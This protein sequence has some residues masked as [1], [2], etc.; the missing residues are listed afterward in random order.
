VNAQFRFSLFPGYLNKSRCP[1]LQGVFS[2]SPYN[3]VVSNVFHFLRG[4][5]SSSP[6][7]HI[8]EKEKSRLEK[9]LM[10]NFA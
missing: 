2:L 7:S 4:V 10:Q 5:F 6:M 8:C 9:Y 1:K 3:D